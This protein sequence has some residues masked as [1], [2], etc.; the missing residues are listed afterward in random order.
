MA[1]CLWGGGI[2]NYRQLGQVFDFAVYPTFALRKMSWQLTK[3]HDQR[4]PKI[5]R[6]QLMTEREKMGEQELASLLG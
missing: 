1:E 2:P 5:F 4:P 6:Q 3:A